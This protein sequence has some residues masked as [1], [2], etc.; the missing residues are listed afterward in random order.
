MQPVVILLVD[1]DPE[2]QSSGA[3]TLGNL[4]FEGRRLKVVEAANAAAALEEVQ[5]RQDIAVALVEP[6]V[7]ASLL[8]TD[9][10][11]VDF[12]LVTAIHEI[13]PKIRLIVRTAHPELAPQRRSVEDL[14][15]VGWLDKRA[16]GTDRTITAVITAIRAYQ[17]IDAMS[18][19]DGCAAAEAIEQLLEPRV[20]SIRALAGFDLGAHCQPPPGE[21]ADCRTEGAC[22]LL[23]SV[24][25][26]ADALE[27]VLVQLK[28][29]LRGDPSQ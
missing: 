28:A 26:E 12:D 3:L 22:R 9:G 1:N 2:A 18:A 16:D 8:V 29:T 11:P 7:P 4:E 15:I 13:D 17:E 6:A 5:R 27:A 24:K 19:E 20:L 14:P 25:G 23:D 10:S 21:G